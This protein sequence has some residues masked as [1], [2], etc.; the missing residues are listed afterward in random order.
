MVW[1]GI[2]YLHLLLSFVVW[3]YK[4]ICSQIN[5]TLLSLMLDPA[6]EGILLKKSDSGIYLLNHLYCLV[7]HVTRTQ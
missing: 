1:V 6:Q 3:I 4:K 2:E 7:Y 5:L